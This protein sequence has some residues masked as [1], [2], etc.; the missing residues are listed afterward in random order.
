MLSL[1]INL[2]LGINVVVSLL[3]ILIVLMQRPKSEGLGAAFGGGMTEN[4]FGAQTSNVL[5]NATRW[6]GG[7]F[8]FLTLVLSILYARQSMQH[9]AIQAAAIKAAQ[10]AAAE[11][12]PSASPATHLPAL[13]AVSGS[14]AFATPVKLNAPVTQPSNS[15]LPA[16]GLSATPT[17]SAPVAP[18]S[19]LATKPATSGTH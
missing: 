18:T 11:A 1:F 19:P 6:L 4:L 2:L 7:T 13:P 12:K 8:F 9:S 17:P 10:A 15:L 14:S 5:A 16:P 3:I